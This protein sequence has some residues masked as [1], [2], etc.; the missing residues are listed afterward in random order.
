MAVY[1]R[2]Y[3]LEG[4][5]SFA[6]HITSALS[7]WVVKEGWHGVGSIVN[8]IL[9]NAVMTT[10]NLLTAIIFISHCFAVLLNIERILH[11]QA[12]LHH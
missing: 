3:L 10:S 1:E 6:E 4:L 9:I 2:H 11:T 12:L 7:D 8:L 5:S